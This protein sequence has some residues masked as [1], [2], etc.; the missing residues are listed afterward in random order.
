LPTTLSITFHGLCFFAHRGRKRTDALCHPEKGAHTPVLSIPVK[1]IEVGANEWQPDFVSHDSAGEEIGVWNLT[2]QAIELGVGNEDRSWRADV[3]GFRMADFHP[4]ARAVSESVA[5]TVLFATAGKG[6][7][8]K[9]NGGA[10]RFGDTARIRVKVRQGDVEQDPADF[11]SSVTWEGSLDDPKAGAIKLPV[12]R[13]GKPLKL[14]KIDKVSLHIT[15]VAT[16]AAPAGLEHF[17]CYYDFLENV[18]VG[19]R[20]YLSASNLDADV[21]DCVPPTDD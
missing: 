13:A 10:F 12:N 14:R 11:S 4:G 17:A 1:H 20:I 15:N 21:Y 2:D 8:V 19:D 16:I 18:A 5:D 3:R 6:A 9:L 7:L